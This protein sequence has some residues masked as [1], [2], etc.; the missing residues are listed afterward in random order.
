MPETMWHT[1]LTEP[2]HFE[3]EQTKIP[4]PD[5]GQVL[6]EV[7]HVG[8]CGSDIAA[9]H[10]EHP[11]ITCPITMGH[12]FS[13]TVAR[14]GP[15]EQGPQPGTRVTVIPHDPCR[16]CHGCRAG[17]YNRC[18]ELK[19]IGCQAPGAFAQYVVVPADM[20]LPIPDDM[21]MEQAAMVEPGAVA[22]HAAGRAD[23]DGGETVCVMGAGPIGNFTMQALKTAGAG[24][25]IISDLDQSRLE[26]AGNL[27]A[28]A[29][30]NVGE[31][32]IEDA[33]GR[34]V[35][36]AR[37]I[38]L[39]VDCVGHGGGPLDTALGLARRGTDILLVGVLAADYDSNNLINVS[40]H[41][42]RIIGTTMY[43]PA[44]YETTIELFS[45]GDIRTEGM[46]KQR[47][48]ADEVADAFAMI[49]AGEED[50][51]KVMIVR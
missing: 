12:E 18:D 48:K 36:G 22:V 29:T 15:G 38:D 2:E 11:H 9:Y 46:V 14:Q 26:L 43:T 28:D 41:E 17:M 44:D 1:V 39:W 10:G 35:G 50:F 20:A 47:Y 49:E 42:L 4:E 27:G 45:G 31:E 33:L 40:E 25:V 34:A 32:S 6:I 8:I 16:D 7:S 37:E 5:D 30:I 19:V 23:L 3:R 51:F 24:T 13:G 21:P